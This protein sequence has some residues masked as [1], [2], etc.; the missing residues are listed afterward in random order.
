MRTTWNAR[1]NPVFPIL[2]AGFAAVAIGWTPS[3]AAGQTESQ[4]QVTFTK[5]I[6]PIL[7]RSCQTC[8]RPGGGGPMSLITYEDVRPWARS[9][10]LRTGL[11]DKS[12]AMPPWFIEKN[13][14]IQKFKDD[15]SLSDE[16]IAKIAQ[17]VD[18]GAVRGNPADMPPPRQFA[19]A[20]TW[21]IGTPDLIVSSVPVTVK[22]VAPDWHGTINPVPTGLT[23]DRY[24]KAVEF[25]EV[26]LE[27][28]SG[29]VGGAAG[30][31]NYFLLHHADVTS[32]PVD[33]SGAQPEEV[34]DR[35]I[36]SAEDAAKS[37]APFRVVY[38]LGQNAMV[39]SDDAAQLLAAG[40]TL[41]YGIHLHSVGKE[42][43][44]RIDIGFKFH[45]RGFKPRYKGSRIATMGGG[46][47]GEDLLD[48]PAGQDNV[49]FDSFYSMRQP[50]KMMTYEPHMHASGKRFCLEAIYP[51][52]VRE[53]LNCSGYN[54]NWVKTYVYQDDVAPLLPQ[55]TIMH[56]I[57]WYDNSAGNRRNTEPR[58]WK[59]WGNITIEDMFLHLPQMI[60]LTQEQFD[61]QV[62]A[63][64]ATQRLTTTASRTGGQSR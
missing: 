37:E 43:P 59:G 32:D 39:Y 64:K 42:V 36:P 35:E 15:P 54:H 56:L 1:R 31:L 24:I 30:D 19:K 20:D 41:Y 45:P 50:G 25:K 22:A 10:K 26:R 38:E 6:A 28:P 57:G 47:A 49:R 53:M 33:F 4:R 44:I 2:L 16:E 18:G 60:F 34:V 62:A 3:L 48:I 9:I 58:N 51:N 5:D 27:G 46:P 52:G 29:R 40:S 61:E 21:N 17:W 23:E 13:I 63:R 8:H 14:G 11:R 55:G 7:Q 12:D